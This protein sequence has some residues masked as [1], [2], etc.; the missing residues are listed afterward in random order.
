MPLEEF[1]LEKLYE[2]DDEFDELEEF[3]IDVPF[4]DGE[5]TGDTGF[6]SEKNLKYIYFY[7]IKL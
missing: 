3:E 1:V 7:L 6:P 4:D 5:A 2:F